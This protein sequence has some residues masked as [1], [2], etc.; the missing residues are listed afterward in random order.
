VALAYRRCVSRRSGH[1]ARTPRRAARR[2]LHRRRR[3]QCETAPV[4]LRS[5][6]RSYAARPGRKW[7]GRPG[8]LSVVLL[9]RKGSV[10]CHG[11]GT[12][13][14]GR[15]AGHR[16]RRSCVAGGRDRAARVHCTVRPGRFPLR[17]EAAGAS[18]P[19]RAAGRPRAVGARTADGWAGAW[20]TAAGTGGTGRARRRSRAA[21]RS[22]GGAAG[23]R[24]RERMAASLGGG[25]RERPDGRGVASR[26][27][28]LGPTATVV[29]SPQPGNS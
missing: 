22:G 2:P 23:G 15:D 3:R 4:F 8:C 24:L 14:S 29:R 19:A 20:G 6:P 27:P 9:E 28:R 21:R 18:R 7:R 17:P 25:T 1:V 13:A 5:P 11:Q 26:A 10:G 12:A 16:S